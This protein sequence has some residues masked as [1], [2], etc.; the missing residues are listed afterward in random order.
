[1]IGGLFADKSTL[2]LCQLETNQVN[3]MTADSSVASLL[4]AAPQCINV[5]NLQVYKS[6]NQPV[7]HI[8]TSSKNIHALNNIM[9]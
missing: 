9:Y 7:S 5:R 3:M 8:S 2:L 4:N 6:R 1:M